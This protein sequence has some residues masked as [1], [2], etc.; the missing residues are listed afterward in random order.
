MDSG[1]K[2]PPRVV[3][4]R[5]RRKKEAGVDPII[6]LAHEITKLLGEQQKFEVKEPNP[7]HAFD[8]AVKQL[9]AI[10]LSTKA[11]IATLEHSLGPAAFNAV[12]VEVE[13]QRRFY[14]VEWPKDNESKTYIDHLPTEEVERKTADVIPIRERTDE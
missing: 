1:K 7:Q 11:L 9:A 3:S 2:P 13:H 12:I 5:L 14:K 8:F 4:L 10:E 6:R